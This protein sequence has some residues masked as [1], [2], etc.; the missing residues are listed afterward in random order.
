MKVPLIA[1]LISCLLLCGCFEME[2]K[3]V[4]GSDGSAVIT[5]LYTIRDDQIPAVNAFLETTM[6]K[7]RLF[8]EAAMKSVFNRKDLDLELRSYRKIKRDNTT[9]IQIIVLALNADKAFKSGLFGNITMERLE[10]KTRQLALTVP[11][12]PNAGENKELV[13]LCK[14]IKV[15]LEIHTPSSIKNTTGTKI[16]QKTVAWELNHNH[17]FGETL[18]TMS[19]QW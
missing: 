5:L 19:V 15:S 2:E 10:D 16:N 13:Q 17:I 18:Q 6:P 14:D 11:N 4:L 12:V 3:I 1:I 9:T 7:V 8:D